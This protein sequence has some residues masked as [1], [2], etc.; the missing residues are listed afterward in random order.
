MTFMVDTGAEYLVVTM[1]VALLGDSRVT[2]MGATGDQAKSR[3][4]CEA[5]L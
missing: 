3:P 1:L 5:D 2:I 4:F